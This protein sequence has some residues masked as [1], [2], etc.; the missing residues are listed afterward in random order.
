MHPLAIGFSRIVAYPK[1]SSDGGELMLHIRL[2]HHRVRGSPEGGRPQPLARH[3]AQ[4]EPL[5]REGDRTLVF[6]ADH[7]IPMA[8]QA[9]CRIP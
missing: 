5:L 3:H 6:P 8:R 9:R 7:V 4:E 1:E 2:A